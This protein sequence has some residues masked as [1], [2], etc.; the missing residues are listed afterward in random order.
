M[1]IQTGN[2]QQ[3][4]GNRQRAIK[5]GADIAQRLLRVGLEALRVSGRLPKDAG[6]RHV[7]NQLVRSAT[8]AGANYDEA[9]AAESRADFIHKVSIAAKEMREACYWIGLVAGSGWV[10]DD[11]RPMLREASELAAILAASARTARHNS[12]GE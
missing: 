11:L 1:G 4:T 12:R 5:K 3:A 10:K 7:G 2:R 9:R 8:G 6:G